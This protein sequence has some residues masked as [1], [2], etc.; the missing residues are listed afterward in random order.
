MCRYDPNNLGE[1]EEEEEGMCCV[2][3]E[4]RKRQLAGRLKRTIAGGIGCVH[5]ST[6]FNHPWYDT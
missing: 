4:S 6:Q 1:E 2:L 5:P 3:S